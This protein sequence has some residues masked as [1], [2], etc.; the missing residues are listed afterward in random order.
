MTDP[1]QGRSESAI[2][3]P[4]ALGLEDATRAADE[5]WVSTRRARPR[6]QHSRFNHPDGVC[7]DG[8]QETGYAGC[9]KVFRCAE[10]SGPGRGVA[11]V[12]GKSRRSHA[13]DCVFDIAVEEKV[14]RPAAGV[15]DEVRDQSTVE[16]GKTAFRGVNR[17]NDAE[18]TS[19]ARRGDSIGWIPDRRQQKM[20]R[21]IGVYLGGIDIPCSRVLMRSRGCKQKVETTPAV[22]PAMDSTNDVDG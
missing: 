15:A 7:Q 6:G 20:V 19:H 1:Q 12:A 13:A 22:K 3:A 4:E 17:A 2:K 9:D 5:G 10:G 8:G 21:S 18:G 14:N 11:I 16:R